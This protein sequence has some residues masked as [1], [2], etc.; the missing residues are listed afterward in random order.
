M[1]RITVHYYAVLR[2]RTGRATEIR[3]SEAPTLR[4]LYEELRAEYGF[5]LTADRVLAAVGERYVPMDSPLD[6][7]LDL[8]FIPPVAGG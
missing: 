7:G 6:D 5:P 8:T 2:E 4:A 1:S 3:T